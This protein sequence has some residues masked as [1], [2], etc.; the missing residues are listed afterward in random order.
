MYFGPRNVLVAVS[1]R[2]HG[3]AAAGRCAVLRV[4][5]V[6]HARRIIGANGDAIAP[7]SFVIA[8]RQARADVGVGDG[9]HAPSPFAAI[10]DLMA[11]GST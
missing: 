7:R 5:L 9:D 2:F 6:G 11:T 3:K 4:D 10:A 1:I 8:G